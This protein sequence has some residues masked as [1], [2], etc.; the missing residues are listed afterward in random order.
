MSNNLIT[1]VSQ[2]IDTIENLTRSYNGTYNT[3]EMHHSPNL[4]TYYNRIQ[5][6]N[7]KHTNFKFFYRGHCSKHYDLLPNVFRNQNWGKE[8]YYYHEIMVQ[9][10]QYFQFTSHLDKLVTM[11][12]YDCPTRLL[13][14]TSNPLVALFF[15]CKN[16]A[17]PLCHGSTEGKVL[18][19]AAPEEEIAYSDSDKALILSCIPKFTHQEQEKL[20]S[21]AYLNID[22][23][24]FKQKQGGSSYDD[25][26][27]ERFYHEI[28]TES[29]SFKRQLDPIDILKPLF[30]QPNKTNG[31]ILKQDG[32]FIISGLSNNPSEA[33]EKLDYLTC[34][35]YMITNK[36][37]ILK[38]L[39][40]LGI[41]E[42]TLFPE[43]D[44]VAEY[45][46]EQVNTV[47]YR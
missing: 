46:K 2:Y 20:C 25:N 7:T 4:E 36:N 26:I 30:V 13:D 39:N 19:F 5:S 3:K 12:H 44:K 35:Q 43:V 33:T 22:N 1:S 16:F 21:K 27:V 42:A 40:Q 23:K 28:S 47:Y 37:I 9:C 11:Q 6:D 24:R 29:P 38:E 8:D 32:A 14:I 31:R 15:A 41:N 45:L 34:E 10:P 18:V 17:C